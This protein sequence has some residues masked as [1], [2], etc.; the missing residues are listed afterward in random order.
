MQAEN[1]G[2]NLQLPAQ[3]GNFFKD[4]DKAGAP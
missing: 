1:L 3:A 2:Y 4:L